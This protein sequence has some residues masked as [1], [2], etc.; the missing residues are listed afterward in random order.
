MAR[1]HRPAAA[2][3]P[4]VILALGMILAPRAE[5]PGTCAVC[6][7]VPPFVAAR[8]ELLIND[9]PPPQGE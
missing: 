8:T 7:D 6:A 1:Q 4:V 5:D 9:P 2:R 3:L